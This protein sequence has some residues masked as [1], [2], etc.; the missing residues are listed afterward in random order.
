ML[1]RTAALILILSFAGTTF[2]AKK[3]E[4]ALANFTP[5][6]YKLQDGKLEHCREG[7]FKLGDEGKVVELGPLRESCRTWTTASFQHKR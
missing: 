6:N 7:E 4:P 1:L 5:G 3:K 2:A